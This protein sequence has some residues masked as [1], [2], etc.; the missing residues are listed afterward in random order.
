MRQIDADK[1]TA[2]L[3]KTI[4]VLARGNTGNRTQAISAAEQMIRFLDSCPTVDTE[5]VRCGQLIQDGPTELGGTDWYRCP[6]CGTKDVDSWMYYCPICGLKLEDAK[7]A[8]K[9]GN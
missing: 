1:A 8:G 3:R 2:S 9:T 7:N 6:S 4:L 5:P